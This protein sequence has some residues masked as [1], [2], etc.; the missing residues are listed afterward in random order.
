VLVEAVTLAADRT[1]GVGEAAE[2]GA[3]TADVNVD[4]ALVRHFFGVA[5]EALEQFVAAH[6]AGAVF[7][8]VVEEFEF[9]ER[10]VQ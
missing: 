5:P 3:E 6:G 2:L 9:L 8:E 4:G 7:D 1:H 10:Q